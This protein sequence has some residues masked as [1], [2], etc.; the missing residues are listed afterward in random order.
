MIK[1]NKN[2]IWYDLFTRDFQTHSEKATVMEILFHL[3]LNFVFK[4]PDIRSNRQKMLA[5]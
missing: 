1:K 3:N 4:F 5:L 2:L